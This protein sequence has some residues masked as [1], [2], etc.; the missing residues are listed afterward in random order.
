MLSEKFMQTCA[1][2]VSRCHGVGFHGL[3]AGLD[4]VCGDPWG[5]VCRRGFEAGRFEWLSFVWSSGSNEF[6]HHQLIWGGFEVL[7]DSY[8]TRLPADLAF[9]MCLCSFRCSRSKRVVVPQRWV[10][11]SRFGFLIQMVDLSGGR[12]FGVQLKFWIAH[13]PRTC[14]PCLDVL[15]HSDLTYSYS[16]A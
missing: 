10:K 3:V 8:C 12:C 9:G 15:D 13:Q 7:V 14:D 16:F 5:V 6:H 4:L 1:L 2:Y 11:G